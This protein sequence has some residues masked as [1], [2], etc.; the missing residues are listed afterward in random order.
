M[1]KTPITAKFIRV[2]VEGGRLPVAPAFDDFLD[3]KHMVVVE[4][5]MQKGNLL[6]EYF[7]AEKSAK[8]VEEINAFNAACRKAGIPIVHA[9]YKFRKGGLD[10]VNAQ[11]PRITPLSG[12]KPFPNPAMEEDTDLWQFAG[13]DL[14]FLLKILGCKTI[15]FVGAGL[16]CIG[17]GTGFYGMIKD[18]KCLVVED[19]F[20]PYF[21]DLGEECAKACT[22]F[23]GLVVRADE[24]TAEIQAQGKE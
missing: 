24:L 11:Y 10:L 3:A 7:D 20:Y 6:P 1:P 9:G 15:V 4:L 17:M 12:K 2:P 18:F 16:D 23:I 22:M 5:G 8:M 14:E 21:E 13:T 19:R